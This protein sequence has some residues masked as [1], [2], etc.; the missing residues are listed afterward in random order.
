MR[1]LP[2]DLSLKMYGRPVM[3][4]LSKPEMIARGAGEVGALRTPRTRTVEAC[5]FWFDATLFLFD[6]LTCQ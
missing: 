1:S 2:G 5:T 3:P 6:R 4:P